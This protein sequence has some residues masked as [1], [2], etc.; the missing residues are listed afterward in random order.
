MKV[1]VNSTFSVT[2]WDEN[3]YK[4][5][6]NGAKLTKAKV[7]QAYKGDL[8]GEGEVEFLMSHTSNGT[9]SFVGMEL[10]NGSLSGKKGTFIIQHIG[11][12]GSKGACSN[13]TILPDSGTGE[14]IGISGQ[15]SYSATAETVDM[16]FSYEI[17]EKA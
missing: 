11:T 6:E 10:V 3:S 7:S 17:K 14:L 13:W 2:G 9:A 15:G 5:F 1:E 4:E 16:P 8:I 12:F